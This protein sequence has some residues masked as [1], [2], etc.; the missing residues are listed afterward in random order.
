MKRLITIITL[1]ISVTTS[2]QS[3]SPGGNT[4]QVQLNYGSYKPY[5]LLY[6][7]RSFNPFAGFS[8][9]GAI[10][11][12]SSGQKRMWFSNG[13]QQIMLADKP[14]VDSVA[15]SIV[16]G[17]IDTNTVIATQYQ[18]HRA[19]DS[20]F[21]ALDDSTY[22][23]RTELGENLADT[24]AA[25]RSS[26]P[27]TASFVKYTDTGA[28]LAPYLR[29][30]DSNSIYGTKYGIDSGVFNTRAWAIS[31]F[32]TSNQNT[33][34]TGDV[35]G[36]GTTNVALT[37][38]S[39]K[40]TNSMLAGSI[41][42]SKLIGTDITTVGTITSG[43]WNGTSIS[44]N[45]TDA[46]L[47]TLT[48]TSGRITIGGTSTDPTADLSTSYVGQSSITTLGT[49]T[50]GTWNASVVGP[51]YGGTGQSTYT[52]GDINYASATNTLSKLSGN[53]TTTK[54][55][56]TQTGNGSVS[57]APGWNTIVAGD[58]PDLSGT[59]LTPSGAANV[60]N[61]DY[62]PRVNSNTNYT[63]SVTMDWDSYDVYTISAQAGAL[64]FNNP[65]WTNKAAWKGRFIEIKDNGTARALTWGTDFAAGAN[66]TLPT[67]TTL[68]KDMVMEFIWSAIQSKILIVG[69]S[70][71]Y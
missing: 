40:V 63:T 51:A 28:M 32:L 33:T 5:R 52:T 15:A 3:I 47:K 9:L 20:A 29:K 14:Y 67:T 31:T 30:I 65:T 36:S 7:P 23:V 69:I 18:L 26:I 27:S 38:G 48:G 35:T 24:A 6:I 54:K 10:W 49:I 11:I 16:V 55:F 39:G 43:T 34:F 62:T 61:K 44:A 8:S 2:G 21:E 57:A 22:A 17:G 13:T 53:T 58:I 45:Y 19:I 60:S 4:N 50:G 46:K 66:I 42:S 64:L 41:A 71:G 59:Y 25:L 37:I 1:I 56:L 12:D 68:G 70:D